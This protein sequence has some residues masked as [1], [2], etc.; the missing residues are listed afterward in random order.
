[1]VLFL[2]TG[3]LL[4]SCVSEKEYHVSKTGNDLNSG[5]Q[6]APFLTI[7]AAARV[8]M[9]G[10]VITV[11]EGCYRE[12]ITP[13]RGG[14]SNSKRI[15]YRAAE[16]EEVWIKGS[17]IIKDWEEVQKGVW[18]VTLPNTFFG[19]YHPYKDLIAGDWFGD[20]GRP[21]HTGEVYLNGQS[22]FEK[23]TLDEV[24]DPK[25]LL[26][27]CVAEPAKVLQA[28]PPQLVKGNKEASTYTWYCE[29]DENNTTIWANF[30]QYD[31]NLELTE[32][33]V[34]DACF[35]PAIPGRN[36]ITVRGF[37][38]SQA[39]TQWAPPT[40]EQ[41]GLIGTNWSKGW[42]IENNKISH[43][44]CSGITLGK[45]RAS[46][47]NDCNRGI[48][49]IA[50]T[51]E[52]IAIIFRVLESG[53]SKEN[54]GSHIVRNNTISDC[55]Q[56]GICG[57][58]GAIF[59]QITN[60]NIYNIWTKRQFNGAEIAGIK[61]HGAI[62]VLIK[63]N[64]VVNTGRGIWLDWMAQGARVSGNI[65]YDNII[66]DFYPE[67]NHGPFVVDNNIFLSRLA[68]FNYS[69]GGAYIHNLVAGFLVSC[70][71]GRWTPYHKPHSTALRGFYTNNYTGDHRFY[72][73][74]FVA[75]KTDISDTIWHPTYTAGY[76]L[77]VFN[78]ADLPMY[79]DGNIY[80]KGTTPYQ[81]EENFIALR[82]FNPDIQIIEK[83]KGIY[84][85]L[86]FDASFNDLDNL[87][88]T[89]EL[90]GEASTPKQPFENADGTPFT[91]DL[92][93]LANGR[94]K[95]PGAGP[96]EQTWEGETSIKVWPKE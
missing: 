74:I 19:D 2:L 13:P 39:A 49:K 55:E 38:M 96:F 69:Q 45:D 43:S 29:S 84:L 9:Q 20:M 27:Q 18:K 32:I 83:D 34:R 89:S 10:D 62:D 94:G 1:M 16:G 87:L 67:V 28:L 42:I 73:N 51:Y 91:I 63:D 76:G 35:Y 57:S 11:H 58:L 37:H 92:D 12:R 44:K 33:N 25:P 3:F 30:H 61:L 78:N 75:G 50:G 26:Y 70:Y 31:P 59:S 15:T 85:E 82:D 47:H 22:L 68:V 60:N 81:K 4:S 95:N 72:N 71:G 8:A 52:Y 36:Y 23:P 14:E 79:V 88:V 21:H 40:A 46:G 6:D 80:M 5:S 54:I 24:L 53:W 90:L 65:C 48:S 77:N 93:Y 86:T 17:E 7:M 64:R 56:T 41:I 66:E